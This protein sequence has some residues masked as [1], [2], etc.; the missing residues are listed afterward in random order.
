MVPLPPIQGTLK[1]YGAIALT[2]T[3]GVAGWLEFLLLRRALSRRI[4]AVPLSRAY[5][6]KLWS[7]AIVAGVAGAAFYVLV[8]PRINAYLP[9]FFPNIRNGILVCG[10]FGVIYLAATMILNV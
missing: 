7:S 8:I 6:A 9:R 3:A 4:G 1:P 5:L 2:A 10:L